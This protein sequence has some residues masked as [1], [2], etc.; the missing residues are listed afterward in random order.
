MEDDGLFDSYLL[1]WNHG[2]PVKTLKDLLRVIRVEEYIEESIEV[3]DGDKFIVWFY[4]ED[5]AGKW[6]KDWSN[7]VVRGDELV[8]VPRMEECDMEVVDVEFY[9]YRHTFYFRENLPPDWI[10]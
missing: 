3:E 8:R 6:W 7:F 2:E 4:V 1:S 10:W 5:K 9:D